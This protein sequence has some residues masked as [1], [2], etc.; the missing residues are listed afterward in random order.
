MS[1]WTARPCMVMRVARRRSMRTAR[2]TTSSSSSRRA[3]SGSRAE[4][5]GSR[6]VGLGGSA[7]RLEPASRSSIRA[8]AVVGLDSA[9]MSTEEVDEY[10]RGV[11]EPKRTTLE[12][13]RHTI[14]EI[15]PDAEQ[16]IFYR[17][18]A[19]CVGGETIAGFAAL[20]T[21]SELPA[22]QR[23]RSLVPDRG[24]SGLHDDQECAAF[25]GRP[26]ASEDAGE[27]PDC[28]ASRRA[29][30]R[31]LCVRMASPGRA[32]GRR[33]TMSEAVVL[34]ALRVLA[35]ARALRSPG[36]ADDTTRLAG[37]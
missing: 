35:S 33:K 34:D 2:S 16:V 18:P 25:P 6:P 3:G 19:F 13:L 21:S 22:V 4:R 8:V 12:A 17:V 29:L 30:A 31:R 32:S 5:P 14:L 23:L 7:R 24:A 26:T 28:S 9:G 1:A 37:S 36:E 11:E 27:A 20:P 15:V 10:L